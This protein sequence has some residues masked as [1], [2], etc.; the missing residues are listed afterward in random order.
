MKKISLLAIVS[1]I[2]LLS[3][4]FCNREINDA[5]SSSV[6]SALQPGAGSAL[7]IGSGLQLFV[8]D[9]LIDHLGGG[10]EL[11]QIGRASCRESV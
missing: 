2:G 11:R 7:D 6:G 9:Y 5:Y 8:D 3:A 4:A 10:A 1:A